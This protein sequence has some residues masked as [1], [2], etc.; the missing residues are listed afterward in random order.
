MKAE[1]PGR[2]YLSSLESKIEA[3]SIQIDK[4]IESERL[5][6]SLALTA[7]DKT[8]A[9]AQNTADKA[10]AKAEA[11]AGKE[12][13]ESQIAGLREALVAQ[14]VAQKEAIGAALTA[15][16]E[17]LT[18]A[19]ASSE[20]A[21][22]KA[23]E[24]NEKRFASVNEFRSTL[25]DQQKTFVTK[26]ECDYRFTSIDAKFDDISSWSRSTD[27]KFGGYL[28]LQA[29]EAYTEEKAAW[30][31]KVDEALTAAAA[32]NTVGREIRKDGRDNTG[33]IVGTIGILIALASL[34]F[35]LVKHA[36]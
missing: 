4:R 34:L 16:K 7:A 12:Y 18:A 14:I 11:A 24:S 8:T 32:S 9:I 19:Q 17:A 33:L 21:I 23:E 2:D 22:L 1:T 27:L 13:L 26:A 5:S 3:L 10:V 25:A 29:W 36:P 35:T 30:R 20:K 31:R 6:V 28:T 15:A